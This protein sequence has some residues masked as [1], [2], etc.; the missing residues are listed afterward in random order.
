MH[1]RIWVLCT[2]CG[3]NSAHAFFGTEPIG[4]GLNCPTCGSN[5][6]KNHV[7]ASTGGK[8]LSPIL[9]DVG[10]EV[11]KSELKVVWLVAQSGK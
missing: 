7:V 2:H 1:N 9:G 4:L 10:T 8:S 3:S 11:E 5:W 6:T